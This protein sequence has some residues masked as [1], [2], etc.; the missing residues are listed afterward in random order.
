[1]SLDGGLSVLGSVWKLVFKC[2]I[3]Q[4]SRKKN[5]EK[6]SDFFRVENLFWKNMFQKNRW[7]FRKSFGNKIQNPSR[8]LQKIIDF[9][10]QYFFKPNFRHEKKIRFLKKFVFRDLWRILL[11]KMGFQCD[12][13]TETLRSRICVYFFPKLSQNL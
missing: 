4:R 13:S 7:F 1:M 5:F 9:F 11:P 12:P 6:K 2:R 8:I 3:I 10:E